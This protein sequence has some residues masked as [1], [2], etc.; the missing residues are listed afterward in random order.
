MNNDHPIR[1]TFLDAISSEVAETGEAVLEFKPLSGTS[2][3]EML[4]LCRDKDLM[5][6]YTKI[7]TH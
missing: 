1:D 4:L 3:L 5:N 2:C 6:S 7:C